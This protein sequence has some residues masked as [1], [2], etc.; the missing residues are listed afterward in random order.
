M[1]IKGKS[2]TGP[3]VL[4]PYLENAEKNERVSVLEIKGTIAQDLVGALQEMD[5][6]AEGTRCDKPLYHAII[7]P[8]PPHRLTPEQRVEAVEALEKK[9]GFDGHARTVVMHEK[10]GR[11]HFHVVWT[12]IDVENMRSVSDSHNYR[13]HEEVSR[14]LE[15][16]FGHDRIQ[17]AHAERDGAERPD[18]TPT[19]SELRQEE[20]TGIKGKEVKA[21]V[22]AA[23]KASDGPEAFR[24]ALEDMGY[25]LAR[26]D[27]RDFVLVDRAGGVHSLARRIDGVKTAELREFMKPLR[28]ERLPTVE[29]AKGAQLD[30]V[31]GK[32]SAVDSKKR[33]DALAK[34]A[35]EKEKQLDAIKRRQKLELLESRKN[36]KGQKA[37][38]RGDDYVTQSTAAMR[39][40]KKRQ[41]KLN[42]EPRP[43]RPANDLSSYEKMKAGS[44][45][46]T[47]PQPKQLSAYERMKAKF[48]AVEMTDRKSRQLDRAASNGNHQRVERDPDR[49]PEV[50]G[51]GR[52]R[53][54]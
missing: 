23:F 28:D 16:R 51:G 41:K 1:I 36:T 43:K 22:T 34:N 33:D 10:F 21:E 42:K 15:R 39:D 19:R 13:K 24:S 11:E 38:G 9:L 44:R 35:I 4:G 37:Y 29:T 45:E 46:A 53:S 31:H 40:H 5:A 50:L 17:G 26:G 48:N 20:R 12:R 3:E 14:N 7:S 54:R 2:R 8:E 6:Y 30:R 49:Q 25:V 18:R 47:K 32:Q 27:K 52:T